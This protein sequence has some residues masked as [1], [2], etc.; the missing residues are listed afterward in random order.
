MRNSRKSSFLAAAI[1]R[2]LLLGLLLAILRFAALYF[3]IAGRPADAVVWASSGAVCLLIF[4]TV[5]FLWRAFFSV[6]A[7]ARHFAL[8]L[9]GSTIGANLCFLGLVLMPVIVPWSDTADALL[10]S[11][12]FMLIASLGAGL[13][14]F[15]I[16]NQAGL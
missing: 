10:T 12:A 1:R 4:A 8:L 15:P 2:I 6:T 16:G 11:L 3:G 13:L 9:V 7:L 5:A 14:F